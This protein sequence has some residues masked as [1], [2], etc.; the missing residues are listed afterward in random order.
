MFYRFAMTLAC[1]LALVIPN[2]GYAHARWKLDGIVKPRSDATG[3][4]VAPCGDAPRT[5]TP[6]VFTPG[7]TI[8]V[9]WEETINHPGYFRIAFS[10][11]GDQ[12][13]DSY[14]LADNILD[15]QNDANTPHF[16][17]RQITLPDLACTDCTLQLIQYM[18]ENPA[19]PTLY[20]SCADI[21]LGLP[22]SAPPSVT[23]AAASP[24]TNSIV[25]TWT[26]PSQEFFQTLVLV[27][28]QPI[29]V[30]PLDGQNYTTGDPLG[31]ATVVYAGKNPFVT[32]QGLTPGQS[33]YFALIAQD[34]RLRF[35]TAVTTQASLPVIPLNTAPSV[36][37]T[38][39]QRNARVSTVIADAGPVVITADVTDQDPN[40]KHTFDWSA[41]DNRLIDSDLRDNTFTFDPSALQAGT[42]RIALAIMDSG[43]P[44][45]SAQAGATVRIAA[46]ATP[47]DAS[48]TTPTDPTTKTAA[49]GAW[50]P[51]ELVFLLFLSLRRSVR[52]R[53]GS[54]RG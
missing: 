32:V 52:V 35:A 46:A 54:S 16:Y 44:P 38:V 14:I 25:L 28:T 9:E 10:R 37:L 18:T 12:N 2:Q 51:F 45:E 43:Q 30:T 29:A 53:A 3:L 5:T 13:F 40:D 4:K 24:Q 41:T 33:Y 22:S 26:N 17:S 27:A 48:P 23:S 49:A 6:A 47:T 19:A 20:Y 50:L 8:T 1:L 15:T 34:T 11:T 42:Y 7:A 36:R 31:N 39:R 21:N